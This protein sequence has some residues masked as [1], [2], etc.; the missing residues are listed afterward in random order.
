M[1]IVLFIA[2]IYFQAKR[3]RS[4]SHILF[5]ISL[6]ASLFNLLF[7]MITVYTVNHLES[8]PAWINRIAH[9]LFLGSLIFEA[10]IC[11]IYSLVLVY[12]DKVGKKKLWL[13]SI[14]VWL[15]WLG[16]AVLPLDY[17]QTPKGN[18]SWGPA[19]LTLHGIVALYLIGIVMKMMRHWK[20]INP[21]KRGVV[22]MA[23]CVQIL[24]LVY[25]SIFPTSLVS[26][27]AMTMINLAFFLTVESPDVLLMERLKEE[28]ERAD[29]ANEAKTQ[30]LSNMSHEIRTPMNA[31]MAPMIL[32]S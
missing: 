31:I 14:P 28:K 27:I 32:M 11:Y 1:I 24:V 8:V 16:L 18:Y 30:F 9:N 25:Q 29:E 15:A 19:A 4:Y 10:F 26:S 20:E 22:M 5:S 17:I 12:G 13:S 6:G 7:D 3:V 23:F 2:A 21:K